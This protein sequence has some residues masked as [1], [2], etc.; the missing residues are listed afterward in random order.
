VYISGYTSG[1]LGGP[2]A[3]DYDAF[4]SKYDAAGNLQWTRQV[5]TLH[6]DESKGV[7]A[8]G[9]GNVYIAGGSNGGLGAPSAGNFDAFVSKYDAAGNLQWTRQLGTRDNEL[10]YGVSADGLRNVYFSGETSGSL[11]G[12]NAGGRDALVGKI[13]VPEPGS[14]LPVLIAGAGLTLAARQKSGH[15]F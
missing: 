5:G 10:C 14:L 7:S 1:S 13:G 4:V 15:G 2:S 3:G 9:L 12:P 6:N 11:G 8:D